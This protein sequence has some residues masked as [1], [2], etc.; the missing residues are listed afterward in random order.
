[1]LRIAIFSKSEKERFLDRLPVDIEVVFYGST[2]DHFAQFITG[3]EYELD[4][5]IVDDDFE[6]FAEISEQL[7]DSLIPFSGN[8]SEIRAFLGPKLLGLQDKDA[9]SKPKIKI[10]PQIIT[11]ETLITETVYHTKKV[12]SPTTVSMDRKLILV[13]SCDRS[14]GAS[15]VV[16]NLAAAVASTGNLTALIELPINQP[17]HFDRSLITPGILEDMTEQEEEDFHQSFV[18][19]PYIIKEGGMLTKEPLYKEGIQYY[20][21]HPD[22]KIKGWNKDHTRKLIS[23]ARK[24][25]L[26]IIDVGTHWK[27]PAVNEL[28]YE[29]DEL[30]LVQSSEPARL[31]RMF[32][33]NYQPSRLYNYLLGIKKPVHMIFNQYYEHPPKDFLRKTF[34]A[35]AIKEHSFLPQVEREIMSS[36]AFY[37]TA[38]VEE[39]EELKV[40]L[41]QIMNGWFPDIKMDE[42]DKKISMAAKISSFFRRK[43]EAQH[44]D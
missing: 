8:Y 24:A 32:N 38:E 16:R 4:Y 28:Y 30:I 44:E 34:D 40:A 35:D 43:R 31:E 20:I 11:K 17:Y 27:N 5:F 37:G 10:A 29:A 13:G 36:A 1:M 7:G 19:I 21:P 15:F 12:M 18:N 9:F 25:V 33:P 39:H 41:H 6:D 2:S 42:P 22:I 26:T 3:V 14:A 23:A